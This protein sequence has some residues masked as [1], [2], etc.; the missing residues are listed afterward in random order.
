MDEK[1]ELSQPISALSTAF[2]HHVEVF[3]ENLP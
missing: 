3:A 2:A 1:G